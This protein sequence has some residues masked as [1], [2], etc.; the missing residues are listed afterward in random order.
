[1]S[2]LQQPLIAGAVP[3]VVNENHPVHHVRQRGYLETPP[4]AETILREIRRS[5]LFEPV[6]ARE[7]PQ[8]RLRAIHAADY[9]DFL[10]QASA[11]A[12]EGKF[13]YADT[14]C[15]WRRGRAP[16]S[17]EAALGFY[18]S[19][20]FTPLYRHAYDVARRAVDC[21]LTAA[22]HVLAGRPVAYALVRPPGHHAE[23]RSFGGYC[24]FNNTAAAAEHFSGHGKVAVVDL[25]YHHGNGTQDI[26][27][28]RGDVLT[29]SLHGHPDVAY[30]YFTGRTDER[31]EGPG[32]GRN[33][34]LPLPVA[35]GARQYRRALA[36]AIRAVAEFGPRFL[37]IALG[38]DA[39][40]GDPCGSFGLVSDDF[41]A[42]GRMLAELGLPTLVV[43]E[44]GYRLRTLGANARSFFEGLLAEAKTS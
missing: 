3:L 41:R 36:R 23:R 13:L 25:D 26:F 15:V 21:A 19:D 16:K 14:F 34:N 33:L 2:N 39:G 29:I 43:Q 22:D 18:C 35:I 4:R 44:G 12:P 7:Y 24:Y 27:W 38:L 20:S 37:V 31:G 9:V 10:R 17:R 6:P 40:E 1:M 30:P 42:N 28:D 32:E 11:D 8:R 5:G